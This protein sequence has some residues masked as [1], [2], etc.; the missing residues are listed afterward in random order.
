MVQRFQREHKQKS[1]KK[2]HLADY[3]ISVLGQNCFKFILC[4]KIELKPA[5]PDELQ[6]KCFKQIFKLYRNR[7]IN[8]RV[9]FLLSTK[10]TYSRKIVKNVNLKNVNIST[11][12]SNTVMVV[13]SLMGNFIVQ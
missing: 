6:I 9:F 4:S 5:T 1:N 7:Y 8:T 13:S 12:N 10:S 11:K 2:C 3:Q